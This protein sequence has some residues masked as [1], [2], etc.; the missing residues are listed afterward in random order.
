MSSQISR[1]LSIHY[2]NSDSYLTG[3]GGVTIKA[4]VLGY[5]NIAAVAPLASSKE[6]YA[7]LTAAAMEVL[8]PNSVA[9]PISMYVKYEVDGV[10]ASDIQMGYDVDGT[11][12]VTVSSGSVSNT[13]TNSVILSS[14]KSSTLRFFLHKKSASI[15]YIGL[16]QNSDDVTITTTFNRYDF[17]ATAGSN[18]SSASVSSSTGYDGGTVTFSCTLAGGA[19]FDGWY[20]GS[21]RVSTSQSYTHTVNGSD[22]SLTARATAGA[23]PSK[24][25]SAIYGNS[26][27]ISQTQSS[28]VAIGYNSGTITTLTDNDRIKH[29]LCKN[30]LMSTAVTAGGKSLSCGGKVSSYNIPMLYCHGSWEL[31][32]GLTTGTATLVDASGWVTTPFIP[33]SG[34]INVTVEA[35]G[36]R[37]GS[38]LNEYD[39]GFGYASYWGAGTNPRTF[40]LDTAAS[41]IRCTFL[42]SALAN[43]SILDNTNGK[44]LFK[45]GNV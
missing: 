4:T 32:K 2:S 1:T 6:G 5:K 18:V 7:T 15:G 13:Y 39:G 44:Y 25:F 22:L 41:Y 28:N 37:S 19:T 35:G 17:T 10:S 9:H 23:E 30:K 40:T 27:I 43:C 12:I 34:K 24:S 31:N 14:T 38:I 45:G 8:Y 20:N 36:T 42:M 3:S 33:V 29:L 21:T 11:R 16:S 26:I